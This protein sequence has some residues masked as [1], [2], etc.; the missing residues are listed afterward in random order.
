VDFDFVQVDASPDDR[1]QQLICGN[2]PSNNIVD[3]VHSMAVTQSAEAVYGA[4]ASMP[5]AYAKGII[6]EPNAPN[7]CRLVN[8]MTSATVRI[9][10]CPA[11][12]NISSTKLV[13]GLLPGVRYPITLASNSGA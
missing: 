4:T 8:P 11:I 1:I 3:T 10:I 7:E 12:E 2:R 9:C 6:A 13:L 5:M